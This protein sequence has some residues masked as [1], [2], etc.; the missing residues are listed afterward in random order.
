MVY[1]YYNGNNI[2]ILFNLEKSKVTGICIIL[3]VEMSFSSSWY[4][5]DTLVLGYRGARQLRRSARLL[6]GEEVMVWSPLWPPAPYWLG[7]C[8]HNVTGWD[9]SRGLLALSRVWQHVKLSDV[10]LRTRPRYSVV[11]DEDVKKPNKQIGL[12]YQPDI[13]FFSLRDD[14]GYSC[15]RYTLQMP[16]TKVNP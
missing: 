9:R 13:W 8:Q 5:S 12:G 14:I 15:S 11:A 1:S 4:N 3:S 6:D 2:P 7:R 16:R 10:S